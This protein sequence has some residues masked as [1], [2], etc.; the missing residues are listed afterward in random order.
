MFS[1]INQSSSS[2]ECSS[3][4][5]LYAGQKERNDETRAKNSCLPGSPSYCSVNT[6]GQAAPSYSCAC[7]CAYMACLVCVRHTAVFLALPLISHK[8]LFVLAHMENGGA[9]QIKAICGIFVLNE[10]LEMLWVPSPLQTL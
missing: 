6:H 1:G 7:V 5:Q 4:L 9:A 2:L 10:V 8:A 3:S